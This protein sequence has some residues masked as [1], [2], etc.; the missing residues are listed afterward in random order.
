MSTNSPTSR[1]PPP[2]RTRAVDKPTPL[3]RETRLVGP[4]GTGASLVSVVPSLHN[5]QF[6]SLF[7]MNMI[8]VDDRVELRSLVDRYAAACDSRDIDALV[9]LFA[10]DGVYIGSMFK[11]LELRGRKDLRDILRRLEHFDRT[12][13]M[14]GNHVLWNEDDTIRGKTYCLAHHLNQ[15]RGE[16]LSRVNL[17]VYHDTYAKTDEGWFFQLRRHEWFWTEVRPAETVESFESNAD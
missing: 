5:S 14:V 1:A 15:A 4:S 2:T 8:T 16:C 13:H 3:H 11:P 10:P 12:F 6:P 9:S 17:I 7:Y